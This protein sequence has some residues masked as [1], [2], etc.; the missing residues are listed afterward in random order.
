MDRRR[1]IGWLLFFVL[2]VYILS[3]TIVASLIPGPVDAAMGTHLRVL[4]L[5]PPNRLELEAGSIRMQ[6]DIGVQDV[7]RI[8]VRWE[9]GRHF[10]EVDDKPGQAVDGPIHLVWQGIATWKDGKGSTRR[11]IGSM[12]LTQIDGTRRIWL[13]I[14]IEAYLSGVLAREMGARFPLEALKAQAVAAR[15]FALNAVTRRRARGF[16]WYLRCGQR[17]VAYR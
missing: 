5:E 8:V 13:S 11:D 2:C 4:C 6:P 9:D 14:G 12:T 1:R 3:E 15:S 10:V 17:H 16:P 7:D